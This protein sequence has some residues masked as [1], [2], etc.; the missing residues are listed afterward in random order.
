M[1]VF[2][3]VCVCVCLCVVCVRVCLCVWC[4]C[5]WCMCVSVRD[6]ERSSS[7]VSQEVKQLYVYSCY[8]HTPVEQTCLAG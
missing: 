6:G 4:E 8:L 7:R 5:L 1:C 3:C 2:V